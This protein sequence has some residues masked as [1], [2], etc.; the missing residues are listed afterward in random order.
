[1][2]W[3]TGWANA[4][5]ASS[6][7]GFVT[8]DGVPVNEIPVEVRIRL[9]LTELG[10]TFI[11]LGQMMSTRADMVGPELATELSSLQAD[12]P[13]DSPEQVRAT[14]IAELGQ[15]PEQLFAAFDY[16]AL[17]S[18]SVGQVHVATLKDG[19]AVVVKVQHAGI[20]ETVRSD[21]SLLNSLAQLAENN[22]RELA[23]YHP[24]ATVAEFRRSLLRELDFGTELN[25]LLQ[26]E[27]NFMDNPNVHIPR[28]Y[29][30]D[31][32]RRVLTMERLEGYSIAKK[33]RMVADGVDLRAFAQLFASVM[34]DMIFKHGFYHADPHPGN[35]F[36]LPGGKLG[37]LDCGK[38][39]RVDEQTQDDFIRIVTAFLGHD[40]AGS[41]TS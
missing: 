29:P 35:I 28:S 30:A 13:P 1:M 11:K 33:A 16:Q 39:G 38:T 26:F 21:L 25:N 4:R 2:A 15:P 9:A 8:A 32:S 19:A 3:P 41:P 31:S 17:A 34:L 14:I 40:V 27:R 10:T 22:S 36:V 12:T 6:A 7:A 5:L 24:T 18:A 37:L 23:L 20:E